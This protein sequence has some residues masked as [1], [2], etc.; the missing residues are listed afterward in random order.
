MSSVISFDEARICPHASASC[1][2]ARAQRWMYLEVWRWGLFLAGV[3]PAYWL[4][5]AAVHAA[6]L[7]VET[8]LF[9]VHNAMLMAMAV[10]IRARAAPASSVSVCLPACLSNGLRRSR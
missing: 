6:S 9:T 4:S 8:K 7:L 10:S 1:M 5:E 2:S 3:A